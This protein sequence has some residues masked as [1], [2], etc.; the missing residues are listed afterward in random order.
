M[1][2]IP[3]EPHITPAIQTLRQENCHHLKPA[4]LQLELQRKTLSQKLT[5]KYRKKGGREGEREESRDGRKEGKVSY[6]RSPTVIYGT[7]IRS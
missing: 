3:E 5:R 4:E 2:I 1:L 6:Q 7:R